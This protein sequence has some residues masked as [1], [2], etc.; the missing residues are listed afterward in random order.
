MNLT[1]LK[2]KSASEL[3]EIAQSRGLEG[4]ARSRKQDV[5][6]SLLKAHA[7]GGEDIFGGRCSRDSP[8]RVSVSCARQTAPTWQARDD[9]YVFAQPD[10]SVQPAHR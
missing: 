2:Q 3:I 1:E 6:F 4:M 9:I 5:I 7:K 10:P 8:G